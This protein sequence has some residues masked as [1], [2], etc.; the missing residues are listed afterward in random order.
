MKKMFFLTLLLIASCEDSLDQDH[1]SNLVFVASEGTFGNS[2]GSIAVFSENEKIQTVEA[3]GDVVQSLLVNGNNLFVIVNNSNLIKRYNITETGL[4][5]PGI[6]IQ[7]NNSSPREM[8]IVDDKLYFTNWNTRDVKVLDLV[9][10]S[11]VSSISLDGV[12]EDIVTD[13]NNLWVSIPQQ[14]LYDGNNGSSVVKIDLNSETIIET[15]DVGRGPEHMLIQ[16]DILWISRTFYASDWSS[17]YYGSSK[18][19]LISSEITTTNY[20]LG[21]VCGGNVLKMNNE[22]YRTVNGGVA[23]LTA[24]LDLNISGKIGSYQNLYS[25]T[26][27]NNNLY[28]GTSDYSAPDT[29]N[30]HNDLGELTNTLI[31]GALPGDFALW[32]ND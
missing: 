30:I 28:L 7:T 23:P 25:A 24:E 22:I 15:Y 8:V 16:N 1:N 20:G 18:I 14:V 2:D 10:F 27:I 26:S 11:I 32:E 19:D 31:V 12:P 3:I 6:E 4:S 9:T 13:G 5:L 29:V 21:L 17:T